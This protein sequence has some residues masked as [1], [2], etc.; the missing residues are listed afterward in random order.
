VGSYLVAVYDE[1]WHVGQVVDKKDSKIPDLG[2]SW[3]K[4]AQN[5]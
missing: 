5:F 1:K 4:L 3:K 2:T